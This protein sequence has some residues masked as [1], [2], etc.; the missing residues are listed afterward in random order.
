[1]DY[2]NYEVKQ[3]FLSFLF[4]YSKKKETESFV[5]RLYSVFQSNDPEEAMEIL[6]EIFLKGLI[7]GYF[8]SR[9]AYFNFEREFTLKHFL[10]DTNVLLADVLDFHVHHILAREW[11]FNQYSGTIFYLRIEISLRAVPDNNNM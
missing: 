4:R 9:D 1:M 5:I 3:A 7:W 10:L 8:V 6:K 2:P 11:F